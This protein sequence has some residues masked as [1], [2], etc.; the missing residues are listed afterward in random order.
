MILN[1]TQAA[2]TVLMIKDIKNAPARE[3]LKDQNR[4]QQEAK[5]KLK[6]WVWM[7]HVDLLLA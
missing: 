6:L 1:T 4:K 5:C 2:T 3:L 7:L